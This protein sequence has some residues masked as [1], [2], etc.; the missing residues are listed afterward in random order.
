MSRY[1]KNKIPSDL[2]LIVSENLKKL[3]K[4]KS[5]SQQKLSDKSGVPAITIKRFEVSGKISFESLLKLAYAL[6]C[7]HQFEELFQ[8]KDL[9]KNLDQLFSDKAK[10]K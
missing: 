9:P 8:S 7:L 4:Q 5:I 1:S 10:A 3:R 2:L 6:N